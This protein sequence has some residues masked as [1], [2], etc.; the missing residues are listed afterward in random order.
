M[1]KLWWIIAGV[2]ALALLWFLRPWLHGFVMPFIISPLRIVLVLAIIAGLFGLIRS[3]KGVHLEQVSPQNFALK[4]SKG[5]RPQSAFLYGFLIVSI[6]ILL[7]V[8]NAARYY[9]TSK[10][11]D[12][13]KRTEFPSFEPLRLTP[14]QVASRYASD[15]FQNPQE[16]LGDSQII[17]DDGVLK[18][19]FPRLP[20]GGILYFFKK[21][22]GFVTV[23]VGTL[24]REV[25]I[26]DQEFKYSE[27]VGV[28]DNLYYRLL[29]KK[30]FVT[31]SS[32]PI[33][34][35]NDQD[36]W[37]TAVP[38]IKYRGF[39]FTVPYWA[40]VMIVETDGKIT[41]YS[42][43]D[44]QKLSYTKNNRLHPKEIVDFYTESYS[45]KNGLINKWFLHKDQIEVVHLGYDE[46]IIH[47]S[48]T[49]GLKQFVVAEPYGRS[50]G[51]YKIFIFDATTGQ[52]EI[53]EFD[54]DSQLTGPVAAADYIKKA[55]PTYSWDMFTLSEPRPVVVN[56]NLSWMLSIIPLD[57]A[58][59]AKTVLFDAKTNNVTGFDTEEELQNF[60][61]TG[62]NFVESE[63]NA[64]T[65]PA[66]D[67]GGKQQ[68]KEKIELIERELNELKNLL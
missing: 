58:G 43:E 68:I 14:K 46:R 40:G 64:V 9:I 15:S 65:P 12:Y 51:I 28:F 27:G 17:M 31:Y 41:D 34:L 11:I 56:E 48:T 67:T 42:P 35:K 16:Y 30:F 18:R 59:I 62:S 47:S 13:E 26:E 22:S 36:E 1:K 63:T 3:L 23:D 29:L 66:T 49:E 44:A 39:P 20:D 45:Y 54:Q 24:N 57:S 37:V 38:Y 4:A 21:L 5:F 8:E 60:L 61:K 32:E 25:K 53:M 55:F 6:L 33:Y 2:I 10:Q 19:V 50:Y 52:R 7:G